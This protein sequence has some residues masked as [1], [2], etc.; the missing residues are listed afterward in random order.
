MML[1]FIFSKTDLTYQKDPK[2]C[3]QNIYE[4]VF[5]KNG[6]TNIQGV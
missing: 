6:D 3:L 5:E 4:R 1:Y 2:M